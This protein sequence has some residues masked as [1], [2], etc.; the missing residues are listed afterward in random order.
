MNLK[1]RLK[2]WHFRCSNCDNKVDMVKK[3]KKEF[4]NIYTCTDCREKIEVYLNMI[5]DWE[6]VANSW[7]TYIINCR[8]NP[9]ICG[10]C[11]KNFAEVLCEDCI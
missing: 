10:N 9:P 2:Y 6:I 8:I 4:H 3:D 5:V 1:E 11:K 7:Q